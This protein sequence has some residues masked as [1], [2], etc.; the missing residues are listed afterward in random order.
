MFSAQGKKFWFSEK[1]QKVLD[2]DNALWSNHSTHNKAK[3]I[4]GKMISISFIWHPG[5]WNIPTGW[6]TIAQGKSWPHVG[7]GKK[8]VSISSSLSLVVG[9]CFQMWFAKGWWVPKRRTLWIWCNRA[10]DR[11]LLCTFWALGRRELTGSTQTLSS[12]AVRERN[13]A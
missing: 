12:N 7:R 8:W 10:T 9:T 1:C 4:F 3:G 2:F 11:R 6:I 13:T 5:V